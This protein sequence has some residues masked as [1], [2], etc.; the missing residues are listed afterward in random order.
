VTRPR[1]EQFDNATFVEAANMAK[2]YLAGYV[3]ARADGNREHQTQNMRTITDA[4]V[5]DAQTDAGF[6]EAFL[7]A[8]GELH[9]RTVAHAAGPDPRHQLD[10]MTKVWNEFGQD[11]AG[12]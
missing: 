8:I 12:Q 9:R 4:L 6:I 5:E 1:G 10:L 2:A 11:V 7:A 3:A